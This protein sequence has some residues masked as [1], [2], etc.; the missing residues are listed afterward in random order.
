M[1]DVERF[2]PS[3][4]VGPLRVYARASMCADTE[5]EYVRHSN[6]VARVEKL[7][8]EVDAQT[9]TIVQLMERAEKA[10]A[11]VE[12]LREERDG[13]TGV[14]GKAEVEVEKLRE[15]LDERLRVP[16]LDSP[17]LSSAVTPG[18]VDELATRYAEWSS[19]RPFPDRHPKSQEFWRKVARVLLVAQAEGW[20]L[21]P[22][23][24]P[25]TASRV[26]QAVCEELA[27]EF[28]ER[29]HRATK[30]RRIVWR[31]AA[32]QCRERAAE[33]RGGADG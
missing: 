24:G 9:Q 15:Q 13:W 14:A 8:R 3:L 10:E 30:G 23:F 1:P 29:G 17:A 6:H 33:L 32:A 12:K 4:N 18:R 31:D 16:T 22:P 27:E 21:I 2:S 28:E 19:D 11:E 20:A 7:D 25:D 26:S 5:G